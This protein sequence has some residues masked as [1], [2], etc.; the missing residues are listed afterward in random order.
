MVPLNPD[1]IF[2]KLSNCE[3]SASNRFQIPLEQTDLSLSLL[4]N[5]PPDDTE[6]RETNKLFI[7]TLNEVP[8]L[9]DPVRRYIARLATMAEFIHT[10]LITARKELKSAKEILN[11]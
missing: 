10:K 4:N 1:K 6:L 11:I 5:S 3:E 9:L 2:S 8:G 7:S